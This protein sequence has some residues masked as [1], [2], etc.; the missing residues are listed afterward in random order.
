[1]YDVEKILNVLMTR[2]EMPREDAEDFFWFNIECAR[3][4]DMTPVHVFTGDP[5]EP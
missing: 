5:I 3:V 2:D 4:G 1:M